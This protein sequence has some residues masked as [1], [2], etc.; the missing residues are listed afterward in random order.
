[1]H[2]TPTTARRRTAQ[3]DE[4]AETMLAVVFGE[5]RGR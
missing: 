3:Y 2:S 1:M 4:M 5:T